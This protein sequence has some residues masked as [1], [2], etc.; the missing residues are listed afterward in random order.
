MAAQ[1]EERRAAA[2]ALERADERARQHAQRA[3]AEVK[4]ARADAA[5]AV[6]ALQR[7]REASSALREAHAEELRQSRHATGPPRHRRPSPPLH[8]IPMPDVPSPSPD[9]RQ[10]ARHQLAAAK[11]SEAPA[12]RGGLGPGSPSL[13]LPTPGFLGAAELQQAKERQQEGQL[14]E[15]RE[16]LRTSEARQ[17]ALLERLALH[18]KE[19][20]EMHAELGALRRVAAEVR[21]ARN[22]HAVA[23]ELLG[24]KQEELDAKQEEFDALKRS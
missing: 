8:V 22:E 7:E 21:T 9:N 12:P 24:E 15:M 5:E 20:D 14:Q 3:E 13:L 1:C 17:Q 18:K 23:L 4:A 10:D 11:A 6:A 2:A 19:A 16:Q